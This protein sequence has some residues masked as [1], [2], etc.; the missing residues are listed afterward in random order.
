MGGVAVVLAF[1]FS[2]LL[3]PE[4]VLTPALKTLLFGSG[5]IL[6]FGIFDDLKNFNWKI[7]FG[8]Q[9][10]LAFLLIFG[11][12]Q[13][14]LIAFSGKELLR[15]DF[16]NWA[17]LGKTFSVISSFFIAFW[18]I[19]IINAIN[20]LDGS[21][22]LLSLAGL[23][24][25]LAV[26]G[27]SLR[28]EVNQPA[29]AIISLIGSGALL[30]FL[31]LN[32][33]PAKIEAGTSGSYFVGFLL[34][35]L[36][37]I[38][39]TKIATTMVVLILPVTDFLVVIGGRIKD[40]QSIFQRDEKKRHLHYKLLRKGF[41]A[42]K[43]LLGYAVF[44]SLAL[45]LSF[46]VVSQIQK[47][48]L[49]VVEF[50]MIIIFMFSLSKS[51]SLKNELKK[52]GKNIWNP[53]GL[54]A[55]IVLISILGVLYQKYQIFS[56]FKTTEKIEFSSGAIFDVQ[57]ARTPQETYQGLSGVKF[58]PSG[59]GMIFLYNQ[60]S[61]CPHVMRGMNFGLDFVFLKDGEVVFI[62]EKI[63]Q[64]FRGVVESPYGCNQVLE[65]NDGEVEELEIKIGDEMK[66]N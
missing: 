12:L 23:L 57:V 61:P 13:I 53:I 64:N 45:A 6:I 56:D 24:S 31:T 9:F 25:L 60:V 39:G 40:G 7:Q 54:L 48:L 26:F 33:P 66:I 58:M 47:I 36:A 37:I 34:A 63:P 46:F 50:L 32:L 59:S 51:F 49:L 21:D 15:L 44:L 62:Q 22:G 1:V 4:V 14:D 43:I 65:I 20:W 27:V 8:F 38:A 3:N 18:L 5:A 30:G 17:V 41:S 16:W 55:L 29:L 35:T 11:G 52:I 19:G 10:F 28:P 2:L 42:G